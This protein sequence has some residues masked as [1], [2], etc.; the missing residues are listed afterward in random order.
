MNRTTNATLTW[1]P[2]GALCQFRLQVF[3]AR[4]RQLATEFDYQGGIDL[5]DEA[6]TWAPDSPELYTLHGELTL[7]LYEWNAALED[8]N[9]ALALDEDY[10][11]AYFHRGILNYTMTDREQALAD[12]Q[13][14]MTLAPDGE[15]Y[16]LAKQYSDQIQ[17][18]LD[19][20]DG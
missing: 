19:T 11:P 17:G 15:F 8:F 20:L 4:A 9:K 7:L 16:E 18:E 2:R 6:L 5:V 12:F 14:Y 10:A 3:T 13:Q 1:N